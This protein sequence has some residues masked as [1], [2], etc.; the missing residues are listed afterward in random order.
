MSVRVPLV[1]LM[2]VSGGDPFPCIS[3]ISQLFMTKGIRTVFVSIGNSPSSMVDLTIAEEIGCPL[4]VLSVSEEAA[5]AWANVI[6]CLKTRKPLA[7]S[8]PFSDGAHTKW[9]LPKNV[10]VNVLGDSASSLLTSVKSICR[11]MSV[12]EEATR[13]DLLKFDFDGGVT[14]RVLYE[15]LDAGFRPAVMMIR[16]KDSP[17]ANVSVKSAAGHLQN[18]GYTLI[19]KE[20]NKYLYFFVDNDMYSTCSWE[21]VGAVNPMVDNIVNEVLAQIQ[22]YK[23]APVT[24]PVIPA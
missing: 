11:A 10:R 2:N 4:N 8:T 3:N 17:D 20:G 18:C 1:E 22:A 16:W 5:N 23:E 21:I 12:S 14:H 13:I 24:E 6:A 7:E 19:G 9:V 15:I